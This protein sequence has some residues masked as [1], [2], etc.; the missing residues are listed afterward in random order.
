LLTVLAQCCCRFPPVGVVYHNKLV[1]VAVN[2]LQLHSGNN[3]PDLQ[4]LVQQ[5]YKRLHKYG[6]RPVEV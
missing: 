3:S 1:P 5:L 6:I 2:E 4:P